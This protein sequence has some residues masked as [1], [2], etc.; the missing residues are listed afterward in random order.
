MSSYR[1]TA[2]RGVLALG[3]LCGAALLSACGF[4][5]L[6]GGV[7]GDIRRL[8]LS[9]ISVTPMQS[10]IGS[11]LRNALLDRLTPEGEP[12]YP[13]YRLDLK[14]TEQREGVAIQDDASVT[15][16][17]YQLIAQYEL[18]DLGIGEVIHKGT[19]RSVAAYNV[20]DSEFA[21]LS[22]QRDATERAAQDLSNQIELR[23]ALYFEQRRQ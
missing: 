13:Q 7:V 20:A 9:Q 6:Y 21:T 19:A 14:L 10:R 16:F 1:Q 17:N 2:A 18:F 4:Q 22:A 23:L 8:E 15:R 5:P 12:P 3:L 11:N